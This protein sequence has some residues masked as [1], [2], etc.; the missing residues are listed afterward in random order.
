MMFLILALFFLCLLIFYVKIKYF[1]F[2]G[3]IPGLQPHFLFGNFIQLGILFNGV[4]LAQAL[5]KL[6]K[7]FGD[8]FQFALGPTRFIAVNNINDVQYIYN[9]RHIYDHSDFLFDSF[10]VLFPDGIG[11]CR[12]E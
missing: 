10:G 9:H 3:P 7:Q 4:S 11:T 12:G 6:Q 5:A 2:R 1:T 8:V